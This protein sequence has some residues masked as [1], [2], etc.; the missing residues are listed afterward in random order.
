MI[1]VNVCQFSVNP[2]MDVRRGCLALNWK[3]IGRLVHDW[4][5]GNGLAYDW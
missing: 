2:V 3:C 4:S 5:I 1:R